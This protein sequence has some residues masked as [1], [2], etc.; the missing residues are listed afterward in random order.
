MMNWLR[1]TISRTWIAIVLIVSLIVVIGFVL[2]LS[3]ILASFPWLPVL[4]GAA[5]VLILGFLGFVPRWQV[6]NL[7][8]ENTQDEQRKVE[9]ENELR[10]TIAQILGGVAVL[11]GVYFA[12]QQLNVTQQS[13][14]T[15]RFTRATEQLGSDKL[16]IRIG[17][18]AAFERL[19]RDSDKDFGPVFVILETFIRENAPREKSDEE[20]PRTTLYSSR[21]GEPM[22]ADIDAALGALMSPG[23]PGKNRRSLDLHGT[24]LEGGVFGI[25]GKLSPAF[26]FNTN[27]QYA[28][29]ASVKF[30]K[31]DFTDSNLRG[32]ALIDA[33]LSGASFEN[34][35]L[36]DAI[37]EDANLNGAYLRDA[38]LYEADLL[39]VDLSEAD[40]QGAQLDRVILCEV[41]LRG[42]KNLT[43][44]QLNATEDGGD[45]ML[46]ENLE[47]PPI[48]RET[49]AMR[50]SRGY[51]QTPTE[52]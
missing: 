1:T 20:Y 45:V 23:I 43:Q 30:P 9:L 21:I 44:A 15:E 29:L 52:K 22:P 10:R 31:A 35:Q 36:N 47:P 16:E 48:W 27:L 13:Q 51:C 2:A 50:G 25:G 18:I 39:R 28:S 46:P 11:A 33:N 42:A 4:L 26:L 8:V 17:G 14:I 40:F 41:D 24:N 12:W 6:R 38:Q 19:A 37:L 32:A 3:M 34:A 5:A 7:K 49:N